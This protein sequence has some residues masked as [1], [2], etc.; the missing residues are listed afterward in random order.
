M[1]KNNPYRPINDI[2]SAREFLE[3]KGIIKKK[4]LNKVEIENQIDSSTSTEE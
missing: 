4:I 3:N 2:K 1:S